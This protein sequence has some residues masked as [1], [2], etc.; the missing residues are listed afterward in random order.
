MF[1]SVEWNSIEWN[2]LRLGGPEHWNSEQNCTQFCQGVI[3][4]KGVGDGVKGV[5]WW[6]PEGRDSGLTISANFIF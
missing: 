2:L 4:V 5:G 1:L 3:G 6:H